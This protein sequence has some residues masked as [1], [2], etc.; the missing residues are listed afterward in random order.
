MK[1]KHRFNTFRSGMEGLWAVSFSAKQATTHCWKA[2]CP[3]DFEE[4]V[5][6]TLATNVAL[7]RPTGNGVGW[8]QCSIQIDAYG[9]SYMTCSGLSFGW[10]VDSR[11]YQPD[12]EN[13]TR[14][15]SKTNSWVFWVE[16][17][18]GIAPPESTLRLSAKEQGWK[19]DTEQT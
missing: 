5:I 15:S 3:E 16:H 6:A 18:K 12:R 2:E 19:E 14:E 7:S 9:I 1:F 4:K 11:D 17:P 8:N 10:E 13:E